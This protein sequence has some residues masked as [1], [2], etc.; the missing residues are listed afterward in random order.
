MP[1]IDKHLRLFYTFS[2]LFSSVICAACHSG[3]DYSLGPLITIE[4]DP[5][6]NSKEVDALGPFIISKKNDVRSEY[7]FRPFFY[8]V[9][10]KERDSSQFDFI[11]PIAT[12]DRRGDDWRFQFLVYLLYYD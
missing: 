12:Y 5:K 11:Y 3:K 7:G 8:V 1:K 2:I 9:N 4:K 6:T 10:D